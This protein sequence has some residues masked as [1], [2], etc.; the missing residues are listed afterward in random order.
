MSRAAGAAGA[1]RRRRPA[2]A[3]LAAATPAWL[4]LAAAAAA[5]RGARG[6]ALCDTTY[7]HEGYASAPL[8]PALAAAFPRYRL[9]RWDDRDPAVRRAAP[10]PT[11][12][13]RPRAVVLFVHGHLGSSQQMRSLASEALREAARRARAAG[14]A[15]R[16]AWPE[17]YGADFGAEPAAFDAALVLRQAEFVAAAARLLASSEGGAPPPPL[18]VV[19]HSVGGVVA[20]A[21]LRL[22]AASGAASAPPVPIALLVTL[23]APNH[24]LPYLLPPPRLLRRLHASWAPDAG[25]ANSAQ[26][27]PP[28][29]LHLLGGPGDLHVPA[30]SAWRAPGAEE[31]PPEARLWTLADLEDAPGVWASAAHSALVSCNQLARRLA[32]LLL[33]AAGAPAG[34]AAAAAR[35]CFAPGLAAALP[36]T[37]AAAAAA[38]RERGAPAGPAAAPALEE[39]VEVAEA[40]YA[41]WA[42]AAGEAARALAWRAPPG[43]GRLVLLLAGAAPGVGAAVTAHVAV[44]GGA[45][46]D[47]GALAAPLPPALP[48]ARAAAAAA[49]RHWE[50]VLAGIDYMQNATW[51][52][53]LP[54]GAPGGFA[55]AALELRPGAAGAP[56]AAVLAQV[57]DAAA[58]LVAPPPPWR[59]AAKLVRGH[60]ALLELEAPAPLRALAPPLRAAAELLI[61][62]A[63]PWRLFAANGRCDV[64]PGAPPPLAPLLVAPARRTGVA[65]AVRV[66]GEGLPLWHAGAAGAARLVLVSDPRCVCFVS[67]RWDLGAYAAALLRQRAPALWPLAAAGAALRAGGVGAAAPLAAAA[68]VAAAAAAA[69][70]GAVAAA[71]GGAR[72]A[73]PVT[74]LE[75]AMLMAAAAG[76]LALVD[77]AAAAGVAALRPLAPRL[78]AS[79]HARLAAGALFAAAGRLHPAAPALASPL[80]LAT[81]LAAQP[82]GSGGAAARWL[83]LHALGA[84]PAALWLAGALAAEG[85][86]DPRPVCIAERGLAAAALVH[87]AALASRACSGVRGGSPAAQPA[88]VIAAAALAIPAL[89]GHL[90]LALPTIAALQALDIVSSALGRSVT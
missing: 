62:A 89:L 25:D 37:A 85:R 73:L 38:A 66:G 64:A 5:W 33:D 1:A 61:G 84:L 52:L 65:D 35:R 29:A 4:L 68:A 54:L 76:A 82:R 17:F 2:A 81:A 20:R 90:H 87:A 14:A 23:G 59:T 28:P 47:V 9:V 67:A 43:G 3:A 49:P 27:N 39:A 71:L 53:R 7:I 51:A 16:G 46:L 41:A 18:V 72:P 34:A 63:P 15:P 77:A 70:P 12:V 22:L 40:V 58:A 74:A 80:L 11:D 42:P 21:A 57:V 69:A 24:H 36:T 44:G 26:F 86:L 75:A 56:R 10:A 79:L 45:A 48:A 55:S 19:G 30:A 83:P 6:H 13:W 50:A 32:P 31:E 8:P 60:A 78:A 88:A